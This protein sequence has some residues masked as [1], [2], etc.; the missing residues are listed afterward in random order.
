MGIRSV[1][2]NRL[3]AGAGGIEPTLLVLETSV[4]PLND[5]PIVKPLKKAIYLSFR[6]KSPRGRIYLP[7]GDFFPPELRISRNFRLITFV[8]DE[9][10]RLTFFYGSQRLK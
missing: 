5:A 4:L 7:V 9:C 1:T 6:K 3:L 2:P 10:I 8:E